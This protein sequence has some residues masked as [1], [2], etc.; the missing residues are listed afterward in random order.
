MHLNKEPIELTHFLKLLVKLNSK[1]FL[2]YIKYLLLKV[3]WLLELVLCIYTAKLKLEFYFYILIFAKDYLKIPSSGLS[4][5][6]KH[7]LFVC[8]TVRFWKV[9]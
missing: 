5:Q 1:L 3:L 6:S 8:K 9:K 2:P 4:E 7:L